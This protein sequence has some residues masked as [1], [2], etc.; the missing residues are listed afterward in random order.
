MRHSNHASM[1]DAPQRAADLLTVLVLLVLL[2]GTATAQTADQKAEGGPE[3]GQEFTQ[4]GE[5]GAVLP[6]ITVEAENKVRQQI[7]KGSFR[8]E[9][10]AALVDSF[11][12]AMDEEALGIS[13]VSG[14]KPHLNNLEKLASDQPPHCWLR[15]MSQ[16]PMVTFYP[17][18]PEGHKVQSWQLTITDFRG[19]PFKIFSGKGTPPASLEWDGR[20][21]RGEMLQVGYPYSYVF[22]ITDKGTNSYNYA[23]VGFRLP[24]LD[25]RQEGNRVLELAGGELFKREKAKLTDRG[26]DWLVRATDE[27]RRHP[28]S[29]VRVVV[30]AESLPLAEQRA[31]AVAS[32]LATN[33]ILPREQV[34]TAAEQKPDLRAEL[35]GTVRIFIE[36]AD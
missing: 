29:P 16:A 33:M 9:L 34:E 7:Q 14:L 25:Y 15:A 27:I 30:V 17:Q 32:C 24:A 20:G 36:H 13:P 19:A 3:D 10:D 8:F 22:G 28:Y 23:G 1:Q 18:D 4:A 31:D 21:D 2:A 12:T 35:D 11:F 26:R 6:E 5:N